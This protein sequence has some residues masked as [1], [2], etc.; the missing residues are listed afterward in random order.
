MIGILSGTS[1]EGSF[2]GI[3]GLDV[4]PREDS[5]CLA[6]SDWS[7]CT[8]FGVSVFAGGVICSTVFCGVVSGPGV[9]FIPSTFKVGCVKKAGGF[10]SL[11]NS[12]NLDYSC[13]MPGLVGFFL[14][15]AF[16]CF[17]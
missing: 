3:S 16:V 14:A 7:S 15:E 8:G 4:I 6:G 12:W 11:A 5:S 17:I 1:S 10:V 2:W 9:V 13:S